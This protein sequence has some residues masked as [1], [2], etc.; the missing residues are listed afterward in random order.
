VVAEVYTYTGSQL[1]AQVKRQFGDTGNV[2]ITDE[3][4][5]DWINNGQRSIASTNPVLEKVFTTNLLAGQAS[6]DFELLMGASRVMSFSSVVADGRRLTFVPW[7]E[8]LTYDLTS[9]DDAKPW[10]YTEYGGTITVAPGPKASTP[11]AL[12]IYYVA[13]PEDLQDI[14]DD[15]TIPD[16]FFNALQAYVFARA[17]EL[18]ENFEAAAGQLQQHATA[19]A[20][21]AGREEANP[22]DFYPVQVYVDPR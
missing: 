18:D 4:I 14:D 17:L 20:V 12:S 22:T 1:A 9:F 3:H 5:L 13:W 15:L 2:Q 7:A 11:S 8:W 6:Y 10:I 21:E 16:R 19:L